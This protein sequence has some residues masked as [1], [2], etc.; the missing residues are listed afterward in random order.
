MDLLDT[1]QPVAAAIP[2]DYPQSVATEYLQQEQAPAG[3]NA[4]AALELV[5]EAA[6]AIRLL[7]EESA[8]AISRAHD[9][10]CSIQTKLQLSEA[11]AEHAE[12]TV[13]ELSEAVA[14]AREE[15]QR[16]RNQLSAKEAELSAME[17]RALH[18]EKRASEAELQA[19][20]ANFSVERIL[21]SIRSQLPDRRHIAT[22]K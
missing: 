14:Q 4:A 17:E 19:S 20:N 5:S 22:M 1:E 2:N 16:L 18:A 12:A 6:A 3:D 7:E 9:L 10:A 21:E 11:R 8:Q 13:E 15:L